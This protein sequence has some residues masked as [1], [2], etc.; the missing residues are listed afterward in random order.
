MNQLF[1]YYTNQGGVTRKYFV[2][3]N[4]SDRADQ[5][6]QEYLDSHGHLPGFAFWHKWIQ[7]RVG[8]DVFVVA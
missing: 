6:F 7:G 1:K 2:V 5:K 8:D 4:S 3:A